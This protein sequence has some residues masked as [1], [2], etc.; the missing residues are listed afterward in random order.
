V[1]QVP[2]VPLSHDDST[3]RPA[4]RSASRIVTPAGTATSPPERASL[5][6]NGLSSGRAS[7]A[8]LDEALE[9]DASHVGQ[10]PVMSRTASISGRGPQQ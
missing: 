6:T 10:W 2:Q 7:A 4:R 9:M 5:T 3:R 8:P 1:R